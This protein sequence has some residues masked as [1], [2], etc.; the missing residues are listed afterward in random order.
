MNKQEREIEKQKE[1]FLKRLESIT[2]FPGTPLAEFN[3]ELCGCC[4]KFYAFT[5][6][7]YPDYSIKAL[8][9]PCGKKEYIRLDYGNK[10]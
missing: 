10:N 8:C 7:M 5:A 1:I 4:T 3:C 9:N 2:R 6:F